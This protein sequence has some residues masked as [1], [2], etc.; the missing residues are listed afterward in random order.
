MSI[1]T[2][3]GNIAGKLEADSTHPIFE[4]CNKKEGAELKEATL[5]L[6]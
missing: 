4:K 5:R 6:Q 1:E 2:L 3:K